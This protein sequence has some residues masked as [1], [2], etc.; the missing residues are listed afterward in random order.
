MKIIAE[1]V[2]RNDTRSRQSFCFKFCGNFETFRGLEIHHNL[3]TEQSAIL[4]SFKKRSNFFHFKKS[5]HLKRRLNCFLE[6]FAG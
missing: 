1:K 6:N 3:I 4:Y 5:N 2:T